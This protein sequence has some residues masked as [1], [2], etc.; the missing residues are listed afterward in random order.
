MLLAVR[1]EMRDKLQKLGMNKFLTADAYYCSHELVLA[2]AR[3]ALGNRV[4][5]DGIKIHKD[6]MQKA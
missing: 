3:E 5:R 2:A 4:S 6:A 1:N